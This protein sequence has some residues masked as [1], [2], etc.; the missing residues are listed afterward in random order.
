MSFFFLISVV[1]IGQNVVTIK[2]QLLDNE[3]SEPIPFASI[4]LKNTALGTTSN[5]EGYFVFHI[6]VKNKSE[7]IVISAMGYSSVEK[8]PSSFL[9][10]ERIRLTPQINQLNEVQLSASKNKVLS[11]KD[12]VKRA[13]KNIETNYPTEPYILEGFVRDLQKEDDDYVEY[14]ECAAKFKYQGSQVKRE[15]HIELMGVRS[16]SIAKKHPWNKNQERKNSLI[17]LVEDDFIRFDYGPILA[18]KGWKYEIEH[19][20]NYDN[21]LVYKITGADTPFQTATLYIDAESF[22]FVRMELTRQAIKNRSW[23]RRFTNGALQVFYNVVFEYQEYQGKM[24]L[25]YQKEEDHWRIFKG[26]ES[27]KILF[28]KYPK[29]ELFINNII[30]E[31]VAIYPFKRNLDIG[32]SIENQAGDYDANF[33]STYNIPQRTSEQSQILKELEKSGK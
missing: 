24:Y 32:A 7:M 29:K 6:P 17:D 5:T 18:K 25:K 10:D 22:A 30:T 11:A 26:L 27:G 23:R 31:N 16:N 4:Y 1:T 33:W 19:V 13:Y 21:R 12:I 3:S 14:L 8:Q 2:G 15:P 28:T 9:N 20:L